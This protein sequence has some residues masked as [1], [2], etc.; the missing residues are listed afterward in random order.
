MAQFEEIRRFD[1]INTDAS[2]QDM[3]AEEYLDALNIRSNKFGQVENIP[4]NVLIPNIYL[5]VGINICIGS[6]EDIKRD[7]VIYMIYNSNND[8]QIFIYYKS[9]GQILPLVDNNGLLGFHPDHRVSFIDIIGDWLF[10]VTENNPPMNLNIETALAGEYATIDDQVLYVALEPPQ[11]A[12][13]GEVY[14]DP[15]S[16][17][18]FYDAPTYHTAAN[19]PYNNI[20]GKLWQFCYS[21]VYWDDRESTLSPIS[22]QGLIESEMKTTG[23]WKSENDNNFIRIHVD[24]GH[25]TV[26]KINIYVREND[27]SGTVEVGASRFY[28]VHTIDRT[29]ETPP[30]NDLAWPEKSKYRFDFYNNKSKSIITPKKEN[31]QFSN[32]PL[33][34]GTQ[35]IIH[36]D[37]G[38]GRVVYG[39]ITEGF[40]K[41]PINMTVGNTKVLKAFDYSQ[42]VMSVSSGSEPEEYENPTI[43][44][45][46]VGVYTN[47]G[48]HPHLVS[49][50]N[51]R[52]FDHT[53][54]VGGITQYRW[55]NFHWETITFP[56]NII[57]GTYVIRFNYGGSLHTVTKTY[58]GTGIEDPAWLTQQFF[59]SIKLIVGGDNVTRKIDTWWYKDV[60][61]LTN[62]T[63]IRLLH[64][65]QEHSENLAGGVITAAY[66]AAYVVTELYGFY[67]DENIATYPCF[68]DNA[69]HQLGIAYYDKSL[70]NAGVFQDDNTKLFIPANHTDHDI[71][72]GIADYVYWAIYHQP[73]DWAYYWQIVYSGNTSIQDFIDFKVTANGLQKKSYGSNHKWHI[74]VNR[75]IKSHKDNLHKSALNQWIWQK[76][77]RMRVKYYLESDATTGWNCI[78]PSSM[79][80]WDYEIIGVDTFSLLTQ[81]DI[82]NEAGINAKMSDEAGDVSTGGDAIRNASANS[83]KEYQFYSFIIEDNPLFEDA[84]YGEI[85]KQTNVIVEVYRPKKDLNETIYYEIGEINEVGNATMSSRH[86]KVSKAHDLVIADY[87]QSGSVATAYTLPPTDQNITLGIPAKGTLYRGDVY[88][89]ARWNFSLSPYLYPVQEANF[90]DFYISDTWDKGRANAVIDEMKQVTYESKLRF[91]ERYIQD[92]FINGLN[93]F[94]SENQKVLSELFGE[95]YS[96]LVQGYTLKVLQ[97][98]KCTSIEIGKARLY[99]ADGNSDVVTTDKVLGEVRPSEDGYGCEFPAA[100]VDND[101]YTYFPDIN[102]GFIVRDSPNGMFPISTYGKT[103]D[104]KE[105]FL[106]MKKFQMQDILATFNKQYDEYLISFQGSEYVTYRETDFFLMLVNDISLYSVNDEIVVE[107]ISGIDGSI[108][109]REYCSVGAIYGNEIASTFQVSTNFVKNGNLVKVTKLISTWA[110]IEKANAW[111][112]R[113]SFNEEMYGQ[114]QQNIV[115]FREGQLYLHDNG[116][117]YNTFHGVAYPSTIEFPS[118]IHPDKTKVFTNISIDTSNNKPG[119]VDSWEVTEFLIDPSEQYP[120]GMKSRLKSG[121]FEC[122]EGLL[123]AEIMNNQLDTAFATEQQ[124]L[125]EGEE[126]R[127]NTMK[128]TMSCNATKKVTATMVKIGSTISEKS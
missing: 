56:S 47:K 81:Q 101:R 71:H 26:K 77:D 64:Y 82:V 103:Q 128:V 110:F 3:K 119:Q 10:W 48:S 123:F 50:N 46:P 91:S 105:L 112:S 97:K 70:R 28:L 95:I 54:N 61:D 55:D 96:I 27:L 62:T 5:P 76:G 35:T 41:V 23:E 69:W 2:L 53:Q 67:I 114:I 124:A 4:S 120:L 32:V 68:K 85:F 36:D 12:P 65:T 14:I 31:T 122:L 113:M 8:H 79:F 126:M 63:S 84:A 49:F 18:K 75:E 42:S 88:L 19:Y 92:G 1:K 16:N 125:L 24:A 59:D 39:K 37:E 108:V 98:K 111:K 13:V 21:Y 29:V 22:K 66:P 20:K 17:L 43:S 52:R 94:Y 72:H 44:L 99:K 57:A 90:S 25:Y 34:A 73:P 107:E 6:K 7:A 93:L 115:S 100:I 87:E 9:T 45:F 30:I 78:N 11:F 116:T 80:S 89:K 117:T 60:N 33:I 104:F 86:H 102:S 51:K 121:K 118:N 58:S 106:Y 38:G 74:N 109:N 127:G 40:D 83:G 15:L